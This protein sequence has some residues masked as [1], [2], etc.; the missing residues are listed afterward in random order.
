[1][2]PKKPLVE[3]YFAAWNAHDKE[4]V[5]AGS[6]PRASDLYHN[7]LKPRMP[8]V[9]GA[10][11]GSEHARRLGRVPRPHEC[12]CRDRHCGHLGGRARHQD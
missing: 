10:P 3:A 4:G 5:Q 8:F 6:A 1:M 7:R 12:R 9:A 11:R 2:P